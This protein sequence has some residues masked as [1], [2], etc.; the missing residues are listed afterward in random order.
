MTMTG[1]PASRLG[2][3][4]QPIDLRK[5]LAHSHSTTALA[6]P[7]TH[8]DT[9]ARIHFSA[10]PSPAVLPK[11]P[12]APKFGGFL[13]LM[14]ET[15]DIGAPPELAKGEP[16]MEAPIRKKPEKLAI[17]Q[18]LNDWLIKTLEQKNIKA[19]V[20]A[21]LGNKEVHQHDKTGMV[22]SGIVVFNEQEKQ[23][24]IYNLINDVQDE[25]P[26][27]HLFRSN[28]IDF[29]YGQRDP[30]QKDALL[31]VPNKADQEKLKNSIANGDYKKMYFTRDYNLITTPNTMRSLNCN[32]WVLM[33]M[34]AAQ[35]GKHDPE[36]VLDQITDDFT[37]GLIKV[38][39]MIRP[40]AKQRP[41]ILQDEVPLWDNIY[42]VTVES[43]HNHH[44]FPE[45]IFRSGK[46]MAE[47]HQEAMQPSLL[48]TAGYIAAGV[49]T[50]MLMAYLAQ[51]R[52]RRIPAIF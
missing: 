1:I 14:D 41:T 26:V 51:R 40:F 13:E 32:K 2:F 47:K 8:S 44:L 29:F 15:P 6:T 39:P 35:S 46:T 20:V 33:T 25:E 27:A 5:Q 22:H 23:W 48:P 31:L 52:K 37:P 42:T 36:A 9:F 24:Q 34:M 4:N 12:H 30:V 38:N 17:A 11:T 10:K 45:K 21:R 28:P 49:G 7:Q 50:A 43:L 18:D 16:P 3:G 19:A